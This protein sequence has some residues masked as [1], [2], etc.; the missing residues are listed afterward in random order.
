MF[1]YDVPPR[2][3]RESTGEQQLIQETIR[4]FT[5]EEMRPV[6]DEADENQEFPEEVW[7]G[8][9]QLDLTGLTVRGVRRLRC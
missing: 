4:E 8:L 2:E 6:V 5:D 7:D 3:H 1:Y 9:A